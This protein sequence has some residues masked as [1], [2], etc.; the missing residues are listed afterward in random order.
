MSIAALDDIGIK[1]PLD[2]NSGDY[3][4]LPGH[5]GRITDLRSKLTLWALKVVECERIELPDLGDPS[6]VRQCL[7]MR[8]FA[9]NRD[10]ENWIFE[11]I[12]IPEGLKV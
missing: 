3:E 11:E 7:Y 4:G 10:D 6:L 9:P 2:T 12:D 5:S 8:S 1:L